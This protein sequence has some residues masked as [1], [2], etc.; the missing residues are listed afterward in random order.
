MISSDAWTRFLLAMI[1]V[2]VFV[3]LYAFEYIIE[4]M[5]H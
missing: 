1:A 5:K 3:V 2:G 4:R